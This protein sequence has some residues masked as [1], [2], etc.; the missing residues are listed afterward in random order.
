MFQRKPNSSITQELKLIY[1]LEES[2][3]LRPIEYWVGLQTMEYTP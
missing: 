3:Y 2:K 1:G